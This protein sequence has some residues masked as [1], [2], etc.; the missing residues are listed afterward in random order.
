MHKEDYDEELRDEGTGS[1]AEVSD[2]KII[3]FPFDKYEIKIKL[4]PNNEFL[5]VLEVKINKEFLSYK[6]KI[7]HAD[8]HDVE[9]FYPK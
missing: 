3:V 1:R 7:T 2:Y 8:S 4:T 6:Q 5:G 9:E